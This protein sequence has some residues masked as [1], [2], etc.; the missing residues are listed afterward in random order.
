MLA[1]DPGRSALRKCVRRAAGLAGVACS[2]AARMV[3]HQPGT[4][5]A[6]CRSS[7]ATHFGCLQSI[8]WRCCQH[9]GT[10]VQPVGH[11]LVGL[12]HILPHASALFP[13]LHR[14]AGRAWAG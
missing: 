11:A 8:L 10:L 12:Q 13:P 3:V 4:I 2:Q 6:R 5:I 1:L 7:F 9:N 14:L